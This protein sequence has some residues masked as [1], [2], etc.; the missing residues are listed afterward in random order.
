MIQKTIVAYKHG[1]FEENERKVLLL[2]SYS[3]GYWECIIP[4][5]KY[6]TADS[7][8]SLLHLYFGNDDD[9]K[10]QCCG[11]YIPIESLKKK[12]KF[13]T[14]RIDGGKILLQ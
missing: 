1:P 11:F 5:V 13:N 9:S 8:K 7:D 6:F 4:K 2:F 12:I 14:I 3:K 10:D